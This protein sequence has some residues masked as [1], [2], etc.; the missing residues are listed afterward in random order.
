MWLI[1]R[2]MVHGQSRECKL[3]ERTGKKQWGEEQQ[4]REVSQWKLPATTW[5]ATAA[6][7]LFVTRQTMF[8]TLKTPAVRSGKQRQGAL[9]APAFPIEQ[10]TNRQT[11]LK[12]FVHAWALQSQR[13][14][15][16]VGP[17]TR[18]WWSTSEDEECFRR[19]KPEEQNLRD[20]GRE[21]NWIEGRSEDRDSAFLKIAVLAFHVKY[22]ILGTKWDRD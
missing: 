17:L 4:K 3:K 14:L 22:K 9:T 13:G 10:V 2:L 15:I 7:K 19:M 5:K 8:V 20:R 18:D 1:N 6:L 16:S 11:L 21:I 12:R